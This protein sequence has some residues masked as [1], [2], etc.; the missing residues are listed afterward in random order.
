MIGISKKLPWTAKAV[1]A[2]ETEIYDTDGNFVAFIEKGFQADFIL[3]IANATP[4]TKKILKVLTNH[5][6]DN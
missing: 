1:L 6:T 5:L 2:G 3:G 4:D